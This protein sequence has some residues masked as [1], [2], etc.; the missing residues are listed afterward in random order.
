MDDPPWNEETEIRR[1][2][3]LRRITEASW[4]S[5]SCAAVRC[6]ACGSKFGDIIV[7]KNDGVA[8]VGYSAFGRRNIAATRRSPHKMKATRFD[9]V[10]LDDVWS[11]TVRCAKCPN[12]TVDM[13]WD[14]VREGVRRGTPRIPV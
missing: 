9:V 13:P 7:T 6:A 12:R 1:E 4:T 11:L 3:R 5:P 10:P 2:F 14:L 8:Y